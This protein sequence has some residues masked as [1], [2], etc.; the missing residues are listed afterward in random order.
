MNDINEKRYWQNWD[1]NESAQR[2]DQYWRDAEG[3][4]REMLAMYLQNIFLIGENIVEI[5]C[6][7]GLIY[8]SMLNHRIVTPSSY[9]GG[10]VSL[11]MLTIAKQRYPQVPF[12]RLDIFQLP[13][14][15]ASVDNV[16]NIQV[17]QHLPGYKDAVKEL[18]RVTRK[19]LIIDTWFVSGNE[20]SIS[21]Q[22]SGAGDTEKFF[23]NFYSYP[24]FAAFLKEI[25][26]SK[27]KRMNVHQFSKENAAIAVD[28]HS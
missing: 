22:N 19:Q 10:D 16:I 18:V 8:E 11:N 27:I 7:S 2:I 12:L 26:G 6:G 23:N 17:L 4:W 15:T 13:F 9:I 25:G 5:G 20:D 3:R 1:K 14:D 21:F 24:K 28:F